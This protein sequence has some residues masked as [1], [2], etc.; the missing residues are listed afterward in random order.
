[1]LHFFLFGC[2]AGAARF[3]LKPLNNTVGTAFI[4]LLFLAITIIFGIYLVA[5]HDFKYPYQVIYYA[6]LTSIMVLLISYPTK[7]V[8]ILLGNKALTLIGKW[9]FSLYLTH[10][11]VLQLVEKAHNAG[12]LTQPYAGLIAIIG[13][14]ILS[15]LMYEIVER[16]IQA[17]IK[18]KLAGQFLK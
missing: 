3:K 1:M 9:S 4:Q 15:W 18:Q 13:A 12:L 8:N 2:I 11:V 10:E 7:V 5:Q 6:P 17:L 14:I 16:P